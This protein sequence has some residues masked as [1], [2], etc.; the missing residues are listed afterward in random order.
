MKTGAP[1]RLLFALLARW[2][3]I[4][5]VVVAGAMTVQA[6]WFEWTARREFE[7]HSRATEEVAA[8]LQSGETLGVLEIPRLGFS[9]IV[10]EGD[11][12]GVLR[13]AVGHL[14]DTPLPWQAGN[15]ALAG[16]RDG[17]FRPLQHVKPGDQ[18]LLRTSRGTFGY[19]VK[20]IL[21]VEPDDLSV[22]ERTSQRTLTLV[23][24]YPF[25][26]VGRA[27]QRFVV[28]AE[29]TPSAEQPLAHSGRRTSV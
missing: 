18:I 8:R 29:S 4:T 20:R 6:A 17:R 23:T 13:K 1:Y 11:T 27:E 2:G 9:T 5:L 28:H 22:L 21:I 16:H 19:T 25:V 7:R 24:C 26:Y 15:S 3:G 12:D 10:V 14:P